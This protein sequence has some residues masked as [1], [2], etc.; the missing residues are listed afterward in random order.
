VPRDERGASAPPLTGVVLCGGTSSRFGTDK[1]LITVD[2]GPLVLRVAWRLAGVADPILLASGRP[3]RLA[4]RLGTLPFEEISDAWPLDR[5]V[6]A[7]GRGP[8]TGLIAGLERSPHALVAVVAVDMPFASPAVF[9]L[10]S[11][12]I[13]DQGAAI[14]R[15]ADGLQPLHAVYARD[16]LPTLRRA[17]V[18]GRLALHRVLQDLRVRVVEPAEWRGADPDG[19]FALNVNRPSDLDA[20]RPAADAGPPPPGRPRNL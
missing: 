9:R 2:G 10:L 1:A 11:R 6:E 15:T 4:G 12:L 19:R 13:A 7:G 8:L 3:G 18:E 16:A 20:M 5:P 14:P 17:L